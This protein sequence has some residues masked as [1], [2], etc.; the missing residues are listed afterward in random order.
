MTTTE[1]INFWGL[2]E[3]E[4]FIVQGEV[5]NSLVLDTTV[6]R[7]MYLEEVLEDPPLFEYAIYV[8]AKA[9][10]ITPVVAMN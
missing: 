2:D 7:L 4:I 5:K 1:I 3:E 6:E 8:L 9:E 10:I